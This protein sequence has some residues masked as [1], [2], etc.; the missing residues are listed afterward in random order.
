M[1]LFRLYPNG[2]HGHQAVAQNEAECLKLHAPLL[3]PLACELFH[4]DLDQSNIDE[5][6]RCKRL[7]AIDGLG[8]METALQGG[9]DQDGQRGG[10][11]KREQQACDLHKRDLQR[12]LCPTPEETC[13]QSE[14]RK[15]LTRW[16]GAADEV[17]TVA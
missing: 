6:P 13:A 9:A 10:H 5:S 2:K 15:A 14:C 7:Q 11:A 16:D 1:A 8:V 12:A 3:R 4:Q 17:G